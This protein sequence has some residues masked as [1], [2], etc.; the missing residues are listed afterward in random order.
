MNIIQTIETDAEALW[1]KV[2]SIA[3][4]KISAEIKAA[5]EAVIVLYK[6]LMAST[7]SHGAVYVKSLSDAASAAV[8]AA[9]ATGVTGAQKAIAAAEAVGVTLAAEDLPVIKDDIIGAVQA[10]YLSFKA[11]QATIINPPAA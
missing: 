5:E 9:E 6:T 4:Q 2:E 1:E 3:G 11:S 10:A 7:A 8:V